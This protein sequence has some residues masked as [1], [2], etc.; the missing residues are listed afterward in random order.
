MFQGI[1]SPLIELCGYPGK[2][3]KIIARQPLIYQTSNATQKVW[4]AKAIPANSVIGLRTQTL[5]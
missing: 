4:H 1:L 3:K 5:Y 2:M